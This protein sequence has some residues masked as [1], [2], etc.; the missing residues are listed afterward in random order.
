MLG[1]APFAPPKVSVLLTFEV[2][3]K[4]HLSQSTDPH[5]TFIVLDSNHG[6]TRYQWQGPSVLPSACSA[7]CSNANWFESFPPLVSVPAPVVGGHEASREAPTTIHLLLLRAFGG[8]SSSVHMC[9][10]R[11]TYVHTFYARHS[12]KN[13]LASTPCVP[14]SRVSPNQMFWLSVCMF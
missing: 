6:D 5:L 11:C 1:H 14:N 10:A 13:V 2:S 9:T 8:L 12:S 3:Y 4:T 7:L